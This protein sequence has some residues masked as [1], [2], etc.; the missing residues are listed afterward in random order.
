MTINRMVSCLREHGFKITHQRRAILEIISASTGHLTVAAIYERLHDHYPAI[1][2]VTVYRTLEL[3]ADLDLVCRIHGEE[4]SRSYLLRRPTGHHHHVVCSSCGAVA[5]FTKC[6]I[7]ALER[8][9]S[10]QTGFKIQ[11]HLLE[12]EGVCQRCLQTTVEPQ[13]HKELRE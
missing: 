10:R 6:D 11:G 7:E 9:I 13:D 2:L 1:G 3:L 4:E 8:R 12:F 5:D